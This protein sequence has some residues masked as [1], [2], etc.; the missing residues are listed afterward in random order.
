MNKLSIC[1]AMVAALIVTSYADDWPQFCGPARNNI[2]AETGL[3]DSWPEGGPKVLWEK[4]VSNGYSAPAV[5]D[6]KVYFTDRSDDESLLYCIDLAKGEELWKCAIED[7]GNMS[8]QQ[9]AGTRGTP[10][11]TDEA[12]YFVT[13]WG[14]VVC[15]DLESKKVRWQHS[16][17]KEFSMELHMWGMSQSPVIYKDLVI[18]V[19]SASSAGVVAY[20]RKSGE[21]AWKSRSIGGYTFASPAIYNI[22][23]TDMVVAT[24]SQSGGGGGRSRRPGGAAP[25]AAPA[26]ASDA[27]ASGVF[28]LSPEDGSVLW[29]YGGWQCGNAIPFPIQIPDNRLFITGGYNAGSAMIRIEKTDDAYK[30]V[31]LYK[32]SDISPQIHQ[33]VYLDNHM[34]IINNSNGLND[35]LASVNLDGSFV[36]KT[37]DINGAPNFERGGFIVAD[38]KIIALDAKTGMLHLIKADVTAY[39]ELASAPMVKKNDQAWAPLTLADG[40]LIVRDWTTL[41]CVDLK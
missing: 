9:Y 37:K 16:L 11:V 25:A 15:V 22:C 19:P 33:P 1:A 10:S 5:K 18:V 39:K 27:V 28:G 20:N 30:A 36:W 38:G 29:S 23:G 34:L 7:P 14:T 6:G 17:L 32:T 40:K 4:E 26:A 3:A 21:L 24:G 8:H 41:K 31:E 2:S 35:G 12:V 13:G